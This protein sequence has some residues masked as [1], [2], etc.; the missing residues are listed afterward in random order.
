MSHSTPALLVLSFLALLACGGNTSKNGDPDASPY[1][2]DLLTPCTDDV[3]TFCD[4]DGIFEDS[5]GQPNTCIAPPPET[6]CDQSRPCTD[7]ALPACT[8]SGK[9]VECVNYSTCKSDAPRC[10]LST[11]ECGPCR[12]GADGNNLCSVVDPLQPYCSELGSCS[13][14]LVSAHCSINTAPI[15]DQ[16][17]FSCR[18]CENSDECDAGDCNTETGVCVEM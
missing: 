12:L 8:S 16:T 14:C 5:M 4:L 6:D 9:C 13:E 18:G 10:V 1:Y 17:T 2:C 11:N 3:R 7:P 15:C